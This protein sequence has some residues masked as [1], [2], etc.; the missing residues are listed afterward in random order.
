MRSPTPS[1]TSAKRA[2]LYIAREGGFSTCAEIVERA[3]IDAADVSAQLSDLVERGYLVR[4]PN[5]ETKS[6]SKY[7]YGVSIDCKVPLGVTLR[8]LSELGLVKGAS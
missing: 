6:R 5:K 1:N 4:R 2:W 8:E 7:G 3:D